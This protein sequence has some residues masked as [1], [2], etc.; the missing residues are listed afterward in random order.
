MRIVSQNRDLSVDF[1]EN[2]FREYSGFI[3]ISN[4]DNRA[5]IAIAQYETEER[6]KEVFVSMHDRYQDEMLN[7][8]EVDVYYMP[9]R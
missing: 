3:Y 1:E 4:L 6:A 2:V 5:D 9:E 7:L 8:P